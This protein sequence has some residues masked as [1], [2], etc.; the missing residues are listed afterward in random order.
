MI[1]FSREVY[2]L[3][4]FKYINIYNTFLFFSYFSKV[5]I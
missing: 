1:L 5:F 3:K 4:D 2:V